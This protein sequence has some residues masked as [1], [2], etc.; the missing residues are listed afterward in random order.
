[1]I[2]AVKRPGFNFTAFDSF[3]IVFLCQKDSENFNL[4]KKSAKHMEIFHNFESKDPAVSS[5]MQVLEKPKPTI[6]NGVITSVIKA[7][8]PPPSVSPPLKP[9]IVNG[10]ITSVIKATPKPSVSPPKPTEETPETVD[11]VALTTA[12]LPIIHEAKTP[13]FFGADWWSSNIPQWKRWL[14]LE[15][16][17]QKPVRVLEIGTFEGRSALWLAE[18]VAAHPDSRLICVDTFKGSHE[19][20]GSK[21]LVSLE[22]RCRANLS[23]FGA[24]INMIVGDSRNVLQNLHASTTDRFDVVYI[25]GEHHAAAALTDAVLAFSLLKIGGYMIFDDYG[26]NPATEAPNALPKAGIDAFLSVFADRVCVLSLG[27]QAF[28]IKVSDACAHCKCAC[29]AGS[30]LLNTSTAV[31]KLQALFQP[32]A[33][34]PVSDIYQHL[35]VLKSIAK[36]VGNVVEMGVRSGVST[37]AFALGLF[38]G[39]GIDGRLTSVDLDKKPDLYAVVEQCLPKSVFLQ[40]DVL[41]LPPIPTGALFIDT[42]HVYGQLKRELEIHSCTTAHCIVMH[43]T[44][45]DA[46]RGEALRL[47]WDPK[48]LSGKTGIPKDEITRGLWPAVT[49]FVAASAGEWILARRYTNNHGLT[50]LIRTSSPLREAL[51]AIL[52]QGECSNLK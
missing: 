23:K 11:P 31:A 46:D 1:M 41:R 14:P 21:A 39:H 43:D 51:E 45:V 36:L 16:M 24:K 2:G 29:G 9:T 47:G 27:W 20:I 8:A 32:C 48:K 50:V 42:F 52:P 5:P 7:T 37:S 6:V 44:T 22:D 26:A 33:R 10:V 25:D 3:M 18:N 35:E 38:E 17:C 19:D 49:E 34:N 15:E 40:A 30:G 13:E 28:L 12:E 4:C